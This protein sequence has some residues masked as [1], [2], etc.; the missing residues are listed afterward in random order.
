VAKLDSHRTAYNDKLEVVTTF[1][2]DTDLPRHLS[3]R[4]VC[5]QYG[6]LQQRNNSLSTATAHE[7]KLRLESFMP[8]CMLGRAKHTS[9]HVTCASFKASSLLLLLFLLPLQCAGHVQEA[10][11]QA[12]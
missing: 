10:E 12:I 4:C 7:L 5:A 1:L 2:K 8:A 11:D 9:L 6:D 3:K